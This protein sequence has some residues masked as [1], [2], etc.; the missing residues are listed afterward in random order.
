VRFEI[1]FAAASDTGRVRARNEDHWSADPH[2]GLF[3]V[4]D[5]LGGHQAGELASRVV[6]EGLPKILCARAGGL[7]S[8]TIDALAE[9]VVQAIRELSNDLRSQT[10]DQPGLEGMGATLVLLVV[11]DGQAIVANLGDSRGYLLRDGEL[12]PL[13]RDH[14]LV[15][16]LLDRQEISADQAADHPSRGQVTRYVGMPT[17]PLPEI[18]HLELRRQ[19]RFL[20]CSDGLTGMVGEHHIACMLSGERRL[21][22]CC[23]RLLTAANDAGGTD[24]ITVLLVDVR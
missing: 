9:S 1:Q 11:R 16:L 18:S 19:D 23:Q 24:N 14:T 10:I 21:E 6:A 8:G 15:Q 7:R 12:R 20:L 5:G 17:H 3:V 2:S 22:E 4:A 13:T